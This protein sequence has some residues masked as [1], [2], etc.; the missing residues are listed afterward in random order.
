M[1]RKCY[2]PG[3]VHA[4]DPPSSQKKTIQGLGWA[5]CLPRSQTWALLVYLPN[6]PI[7]FNPD[8]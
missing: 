2:T 3:C 8:G 4:D 1:Y 7:H 6:Q 5:G